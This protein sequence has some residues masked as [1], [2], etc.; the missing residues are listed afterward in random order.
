MGFLGRITVKAKLR[1]L[2]AI[3]LGLTGLLLVSDLVSMAQVQQR[4][5][6]SV[7]ASDLGATGAA[8]ALAAQADFKTQVQEFKDLLLRGQEPDRLAK[9]KGGF[10]KKAVEVQQDLVKVGEILPTLGLDARLAEPSLQAHAEVTARYKAAMDAFDP[11]KPGSYIEGDK[12]VRGIDRALAEAMGNLAAQVAKRAEDMRAEGVQSTKS[13]LRNS[14]LFQLV[15]LVVGAVF[16]LFLSTLIAGKISGPL[17]RVAAGM[18]RFSEGD[19]RGQLN[20]DSSDELGQMA[21]SYND[22]GA[23]FRDLFDQLREAGERV[24]SGSTELTATASEMARATAE[25]AQFAEGQRAISER[26][27]VAMAQLNASIQQVSTSVHSSTERTQATVAA[28]GEG[29]HQGEATVR[30]MGAIQEAIG[31]MV[32]AVQVIQEI[33]RQT[34][35][36]SLNAA[37]EAAKA[38][39]QGKGFAV[40]AEE[41]R[42]LAERSAGAAKEIG[43]L[44]QRTAEAMREG[45]RTVEA[46]V[47]T[48]SLIRSHVQ[49]V[50]G[51]ANGIG[52]ATLEQSHTSREVAQQ[53]ADGAAATARSA[54]ASTELAITVEEINR[55]SEVLARVAE[56]LAASV[57]Q[58][59][60]A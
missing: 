7:K 10:E 43:E 52:V 21:Q 50:A 16:A 49:E 4:F 22:L 19:L 14:V 31:Q 37:I 48:F 18:G 23:R 47:S 20:I 41:V 13:T 58:Y 27:A 15:L 36:L 9:H 30:A 11:S 6:A 3:L 32:R 34:N 42:K 44:I 28:A 38:G 56:E 59:R 33:A 53:V 26:T 29:T 8:L 60:T 45:K 12:R 40:V 5:L 17:Q 39:V 2:V 25:I 46:T 54:A 55:A 1:L 35:L 57:R 51:T 24:A